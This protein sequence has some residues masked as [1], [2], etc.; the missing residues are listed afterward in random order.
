MELNRIEIFKANKKYNDDIQKA[1][2]E[3]LQSANDI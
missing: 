3:L 1:Y 2:S